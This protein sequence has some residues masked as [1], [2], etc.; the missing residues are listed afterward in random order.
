MGNGHVERMADG[1][2]VSA[3]RNF[4]V[5]GS[6]GRGRPW[7]NWR[8]RLEGDMKEMGLRPELAMDRERWRCGIMRK[9][10]EPY[11]LGNYRR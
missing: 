1:D 9:T 6:R 10:S 3:C 11:R 7:M 2:W 4:E 8:E 5:A